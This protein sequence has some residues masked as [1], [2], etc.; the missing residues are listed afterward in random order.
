MKKILLLL[1]IYGFVSCSKS[2][3][4]HCYECDIT[5]TGSGT[6]SDVGCYTNDE[7]DKHNITDA[8]G[9][10]LNKSQRCRKK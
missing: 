4:T 5:S 10:D 2:N 1:A 3:D 8:L 6:Y 9:N 7:W